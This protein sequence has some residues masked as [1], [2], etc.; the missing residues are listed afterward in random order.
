VVELSC[1]A[2]GHDNCEFMICMRGQLERCAKNY[3]EAH[4]R[5]GLAPNIP[6]LDILLTKDVEPK[7]EKGKSR[8]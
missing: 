8:K 1:R 4:G 7:K 3:L 5:G 2:L 6:L